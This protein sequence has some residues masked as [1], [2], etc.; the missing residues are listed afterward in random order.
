MFLLSGFL[1]SVIATKHP[2][3][4]YQSREVV[5][6]IKILRGNWEAFLQPRFSAISFFI[7]VWLSHNIVFSTVTQLYIQFFKFFPLI[8]FYKI[9]S[10]VH[11]A[12]QQVPVGYLFLHIEVYMCS[13]QPPNFS[14][15]I[16]FHQGCYKVLNIVSCVLQQ[17]LVLYFICSQCHL[18]WLLKH[19]PCWHLPRPALV[20]KH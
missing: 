12:I 1:L 19:R 20:M 7:E 5:Q 4:A 2:G 3:V 18:G 14:S 11:Y 8:G 17:V 16:L 9:L 10:S 15:Q 6:A 13:S